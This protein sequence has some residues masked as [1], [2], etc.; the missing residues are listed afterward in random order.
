MTAPVLPMRPG[1]SPRRWQ[2]EALTA[3]LTAWGEGCSRP[4]LS[5][6]T[7]S[8]KGDWIAGFARRAQAKGSRVLIL[9]HLEN[10]VV[11]LYQ[12]II[13]VPGGKDPGMVMGA[14]NDLGAAIIVASV[15][16]LRQPERLA[17]LGRVDVMITDEAH[18]AT[19][20]GYEDVRQAILRVRQAQAC[21]RPLMSIGLTATPYRSGS[22]GETEGLGSVYDALV[23]GYTL[24][25][26]VAD[27]VLVPPVLRRYDL[28]TAQAVDATRRIDSPEI[29]EVVATEWLAQCQGRHGLAFGIDR[30]H[31]ERLAHALRAVGVRAQAIDGGMAAG[32]QADL[33]RLYRVGK[34]DVLCSCDLIRE[35]FDMPLADALL[36]CRPSE[37]PIVGLQMLGRGLRTYPGKADCLVLDFTGGRIDFDLTRDADLSE[38]P[39]E[40]AAEL[41]ARPLSPGETVVHRHR[42]ALGLGVVVAAGVVVRV[43][44]DTGEELLHGPVELVR[45]SREELEQAAV[46]VLS[47]QGYAVEL[48]PWAPGQGPR[49][50]PIPWYQGP[51]E[52]APEGRQ[53]WSAGLVVVRPGRA[54][55]A[56]VGVVRPGATGW[57]PWLVVTVPGAEGPP[58]VPW[59]CPPPVVECRRLGD[60]RPV[61]DIDEA[62]GIAEAALRVV[63][64]VEMPDLTDTTGARPLS[65]AMRDR[66][67]RRG[68]A[69]DRMPATHGEGRAMLYAVG[70]LAEV[71][72]VLAEQRKEAVK[73]RNGGGQ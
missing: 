13:A 24:A 61:R 51:A 34:I 16:S 14:A 29:C 68:V 33:L 18:H 20:A 56:A 69:A 47:V 15:Q 67:R 52:T 12:R 60:R 55:G 66:L 31:A 72:A 59:C 71:A 3:V 2:I 42:A 40:D 19:A 27:G 38:R 7:G 35:G 26:G 9:V 41:K 63:P 46:Q 54:P 23:Y 6:A 32:K 73:R 17:A 4:L 30:R 50:S 10:L 21:T 53:G 36:V 62:R 5:V 49:P 58:D 28:T 64:G 25:D 48:L 22:G 57:H 65:A 1:Y 43:R 37:S 11:D 8:G 70:A 45:R 44:W 39:V